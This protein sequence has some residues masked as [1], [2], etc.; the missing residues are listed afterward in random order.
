MAGLHCRQLLIFAQLSCHKQAY[1][2]VGYK[3][4]HTHTPCIY[5]YIYSSIHLYT[6]IGSYL[7]QLF[8][9]EMLIVAL[10]LFIRIFAYI[11]A[12]MSVCMYVF[13]IIMYAYVAVFAL[14][15]YPLV[16]AIYVF[17]S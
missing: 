16:G 4:S 10:S 13:F 12:C 6:Y 15:L 14:N 3:Q 8:A 1:N 17:V 9:C 2:K 5:I 7:I 11:C